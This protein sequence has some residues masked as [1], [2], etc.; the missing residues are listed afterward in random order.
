MLRA[1]GYFRV[2]TQ[3][4]AREG[5]S[6]ETQENLARKYCEDRGW[7][8]VDTYVDVQS[9]RSDRRPQLKRMEQ[10]AQAR[11]FDVV[12]V[13]KLDRLARST[14]TFY[15]I[16][17]AFR[18]KDIALASLTEDLD[19]TSI[20]GKAMMGMLAIF[21]EIFSDQLSERVKSAMQTVAA[22]SQWHTGAKAP[23]GYR[24]I[25]RQKLEDGTETE[26]TVEVIPSEAEVVRE[27]FAT[28]L[29]IRSLR[30][31]CDELFRRGIRTKTGYL[32]QSQTL[33][34][35]L[36]N[37]AYIG[38]SAWGKYQGSRGGRRARIP[39]DPSTWIITE[40]THEA[41]IDRETWHEAQRILAGNKQLNGR[42][43]YARRHYAWNGMVRC[44][45]AR[46]DGSHCGAA[47]TGR[48]TKNQRTRWAEVVEYY[49]NAYIDMGT[50]VCPDRGRLTD[51]FLDWI[52]IPRLDE[53]LQSV[54]V[55]QA[56][57]NQKPKKRTKGE[58]PVKKIAALEARRAREK[59]LFREGFSTFDEM[60]ANIKK[61]D[62]EIEQL[63]LATAAP[64][65]LPV[66]PTGLSEVWERLN[67]V[68]QRDLIQSFVA[69]GEA[70]R[71]TFR[72]HLRPYDHPDWPDVLEI[73]IVRTRRLTEQKKKESRDNA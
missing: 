73:P 72:L 39:T 10:D 63:K 23:F 64:V 54:G 66:L 68:E 43:I 58:D 11:K 46:A 44:G 31:T 52:V 50:A 37:P 27:I 32:W 61:L 3:D 14:A 5:V 15:R 7:A 69:Y 16:V 38:S 30:A 70:T 36:R 2:S 35:F 9:G 60:A 20:Q 1:V 4:Q 33:G 47:M 24:L 71:T 56:A 51:K 34:Y 18:E 42:E 19:F 40:G 22:K 6:L 8:M 59:D 29:Q 49:C 65:P 53:L 26:P 28:F 57:R 12:I 67:P 17:T 45:G 13:Y 48:T 21:A 25:P 41:I 55:S 62:A